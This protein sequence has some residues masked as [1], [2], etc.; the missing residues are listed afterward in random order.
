MLSIRVIIERLNY[1]AGRMQPVSPGCEVGPIGVAAVGL[2]WSCQW[3]VVQLFGLPVIRDKVDKNSRK[4]R[5]GQGRVV[6]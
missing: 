6:G 1:R 2:S 3:S 4:C 5:S